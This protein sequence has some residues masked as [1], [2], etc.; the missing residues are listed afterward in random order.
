MFNGNKIKYSTKGNIQKKSNEK[1][2]H[3]EVTLKE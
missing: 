2:R 1:L 3:N